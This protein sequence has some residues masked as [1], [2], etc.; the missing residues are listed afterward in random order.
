MIKDLFIPR[1]RK[2]VYNFS[3]YNN[4]GFIYHPFAKKEYKFSIHNNNKFIYAENI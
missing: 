4:N 1:L 2:R 3:I